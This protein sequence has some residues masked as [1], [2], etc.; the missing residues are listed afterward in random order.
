MNEEQKESPIREL[1]QDISSNSD[2]SRIPPRG[3]VRPTLINRIT[4]F[5]SLLCLLLTTAIFLA[6]MWDFT[7]PAFGFRCIGSILV[8]LL[9]LFLFRAINE[10][11]D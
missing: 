8:I 5:A 11:F 4:L 9:A 7:D 1:L 10:Q 2:T 3:L 6:M